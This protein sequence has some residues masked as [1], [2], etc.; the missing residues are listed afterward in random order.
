MRNLGK[1]G[2]ACSVTCVQV[3]PDHPVK[4][5]PNPS[6][7]KWGLSENWNHLCFPTQLHKSCSRKQ[8]IPVLG[9][10]DHF[11]EQLI[12][13]RRRRVIF[14]LGPQTCPQPYKDT[15]ISPPLPLSPFDYVWRRY[16]KCRPPQTPHQ[17]YA[18]IFLNTLNWNG[19]NTWKK[20]VDHEKGARIEKRK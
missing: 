16:Q 18:F 12:H 10:W 17:G 14:F 7:N 3:R 9:E 4:R 6:L 2:R 8:L 5:S 20:S 13:L 15:R 1:W 19:E 11:R